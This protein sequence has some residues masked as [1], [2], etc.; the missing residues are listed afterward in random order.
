MASRK[1]YAA[2]GATPASARAQIEAVGP[3][4]ANGPAPTVGQVLTWSGTAWVPGTGGGGGSGGLVWPLGTPW[5]TMIPLLAT[6]GDAAI[7]LVEGDPTG[8]PRQITGK[9]DGFGGYLT[10][11]FSHVIF[12][13][14]SA[15]GTSN[16]VSVE[17]GLGVSID[18]GILRSRDIMWL[19]LYPDIVGGATPA[20]E[21]DFDGGGL[22]PPGSLA[23][24]SVL[25]A[26]S[27]EANSIRLRNGAIIDGTNLLPGEA[28][29]RLRPSFAGDVV[30]NIESYGG[31]VGPN[32]FIN[33]A[34]VGPGPFFPPTTAVVF[35]NM[36]AKTVIDPNFQAPGGVSN[37]ACSQDLTKRDTSAYIAYDDALAVPPL[38]VVNVQ[39]AIDALKASGLSGVLGVGNVS[40]TNDILITAGQALDAETALGTLM[41]G[42]GNAKIVALGNNTAALAD[43]D[44][45]VVINQGGSSFISNAGMQ[46]SS[47]RA[48]RAQFRGNQFGA[49]NAGAGATGFKSRGANIG[50]MLSVAAGDILYR[51]TA[52]GVPADNVS[53]PLAALLS[54]Q[55]PTAGV[56]ANYV[57]TELELQLVPLEGPINGAKV[58]FKITS[59]GVPV[60][61]ETALPGGGAAA[62]LAVLGA[63]G[64]ITVANPNVLAGTRFTLT[65]QDGGAAPSG[66]LIYVSARVAG[67]SFTITSVAGAGD[68]GV[69]VYW[70]L[71]E[72]V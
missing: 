45:I 56:G 22:T 12:V 61:R 31:I 63:G 40:G 26:R 3:A 62:G 72:S 4:P 16:T 71:W 69:Q 17:L 44:P 49:N 57:A 54:L 27:G 6:A 9:P 21:F 38:G 2:I 18:P 55:V 5:S 25:R 70:Q 41:L 35:L 1:Y 8:A 20:F 39:D 52:I 60:L 53:V 64:S 48:N 46:F 28:I 42:T 51:I 50:D 19:P 7:L 66:S 65:V 33:F 37:V 10:Q 13:G 43:D 15:D 34:P 47:K 29:S 32:S 58:M 36:D 68:A 23:A 24:G 30:L 59:Q 11:D 67:A 14:A